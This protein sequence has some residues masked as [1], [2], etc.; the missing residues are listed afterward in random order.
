MNEAEV[1]KKVEAWLVDQDYKFVV[2]EFG[3]EGGRLDFLGARWLEGG[4]EI[5]V[6]GVEC[7]GE[8]YAAEVWR[9]ANEQLGRYGRCVPKLYFAC[10]V[11]NPN[12]GEEFA[13]LCR[14]AGVGFIGVGS[15]GADV[16]HRPRDIGP[17][18][19]WVR[20]MEE[21]R[22]RVALFLA[23]EDVFGAD[24]R[25][26]Q[27]WCATN[28]P[29]DRAQW[30]AFVDRAKGRCYLG[31]NVENSK[32][33]LRKLDL[34]EI[35]KV[36]GALP[37]ETKCQ[38]WRHVFFGPGRRASMPLL[39][40]TASMLAVG[41]LEH[42]RRVSSEQAVGLWVG[43]PVWDCGDALGRALHCERIRKA[44]DVLKPLYVCMGGQGGEQPSGEGTGGG[45]EGSGSRG[46]SG[47][48]AWGG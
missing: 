27:D 37:R 8:T 33:M 26:G 36:L 22:S 3:I 41:D 42:L 45:W 2:R 28:E 12:Q 40:G 9:I 1:R 10:S 13:I 17:R 20:Y 31:V 23:F 25:R 35:A 46:S 47:R 43:L 11:A 24:Q 32:R 4:Y 14:T 38:V 48:V 34:S 18:L 6:V 39:M 21:V 19:D 30:G 44:G 15:A 7:K 5:E 16:K 29:T